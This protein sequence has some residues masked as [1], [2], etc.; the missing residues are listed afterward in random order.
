VISAQRVHEKYFPFPVCTTVWTAASAAFKPSFA[1][2]FPVL[3]STY[4]FPTFFFFAVAGGLGRWRVLLFG[5]G[6]LRWGD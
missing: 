5:G 3:R 1:V 2:G 6:R 4:M